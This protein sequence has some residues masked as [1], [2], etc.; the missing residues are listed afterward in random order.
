MKTFLRLT[1]SPH[2]VLLLLVL[3][4]ARPAASQAQRAG[5]QTD[6]PPAPA[7]L[8]VIIRP[9]P[10]SPLLRVCY[11]S[12]QYGS[13]RFQIRNERGSV[14]YSDVLR[15]SRYVGTFDLANLP[16]G[17]YTVGLQTPTDHHEAAIR[18]VQPIPVAVVSMAKEQQEP[19]VATQ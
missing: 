5:A 16:S 7:A 3:G 13:V 10:N 9:L 17:R 14:V 6:G 15:A 8:R 1:T 11:E 4:F 18:V 12:D 2:W 19:S